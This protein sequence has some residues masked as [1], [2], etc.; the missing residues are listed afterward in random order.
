MPPPGECRATDLRPTIRHTRSGTDR[1]PAH[2][3]RHADDGLGSIHDL[4]AYGPTGIPLPGSHWGT[5]RGMASQRTGC[6]EPDTP[7]CIALESKGSAREAITGLDTIQR[8]C[9][10]RTTT[11]GETASKMA[12]M[13]TQPKRLQTYLS[14]NW[15]W[16]NTPAD[17][18]E[19]AY[20][21][22]DRYHSQFHAIRF[23]LR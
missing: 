16:V 14:G 12:S 18:R 5:C 8:S 15:P 7:S 4:Q 13:L 17:P 1:V 20:D 10:N 23:P 21:Y 3:I 11:A 9:S 19:K 6:L 2:G 22:Q